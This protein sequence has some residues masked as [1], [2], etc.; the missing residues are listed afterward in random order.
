MQQNVS[1]L[2]GTMNTVVFVYPGR[3]TNC[4]KGQ[5][6]RK[7]ERGR[8]SNNHHR[9]TGGQ[10]HVASTKPRTGVRWASQLATVVVAAT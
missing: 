10:A 7:R 2:I 5:T 1:A 6:N 8:D 4:K 9:R 3:L